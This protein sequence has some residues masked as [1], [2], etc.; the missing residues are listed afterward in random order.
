MYKN[1]STSNPDVSG[2]CHLKVKLTNIVN[3]LN[4]P[5]ICKIVA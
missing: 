1:Y 4:L 3:T 5:S 2:I